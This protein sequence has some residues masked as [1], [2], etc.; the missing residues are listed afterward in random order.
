MVPYG[1]SSHE[2]PVNGGVLQ[3]S[4]LGATPFVLYIDDL[5]DD[6]ISNIAIYTD[7]TTLY[8]ECN[9]ASDLW[10][11]LELAAEFESDLQD[12]VDWGRKKFVDFNVGKTQLLLFDWYNNTFATDVSMDGSVLEEKSSFKILGLCF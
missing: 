3:G 7:D 12:T 10:Q 8:S 5:F 6:V 1:K 2:Y 4:I 11:Q 9:Q